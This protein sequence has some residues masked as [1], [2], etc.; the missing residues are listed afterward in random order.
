MNPCPTRRSTRYSFLDLLGQSPARAEACRIAGA[1]AANTLPVLILGESSVGKELFAQSIHGA[2]ERR[3]RPFVAVNCGALP[4]ELVESELFGYVG[5]AFS[6]AR[7]EGSPGKF[8]AAD[9]GTIFLDEIGELPPGAQTALLR[10][11]QEG[12][13][14]R[15]GGAQAKPVDVRVIAA[16]NRDLQAALAD[17]S[18]RRDLYY[19]LNVITLELPPLRE[20]RED[21]PLLARH[22]LET[23]STAM[24]KRGLTFDA[25]GSTPCRGMIGRATCASC[26]TWS[27][28][29]WPWR[30][31]AAS[32]WPISPRRSVRVLRAGLHSQLRILPDSPADR[33][34]L[35]PSWTWRR[36]ARSCWRSS[37][38]R[39]P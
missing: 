7:R 12:K 15:V 18:L 11:L 21:I 34:A 8:E 9:G 27:P 13:I 32:R 35:Y 29:W 17:G 20:R 22:F 37:S 31:P 19:R 3:D 39:A 5:G 10:V 6:G 36:S 24:R 16:T 23:S 30:P 1:A 26:R 2:S 33:G 28:G 25:E 4:G 14:T 38:R